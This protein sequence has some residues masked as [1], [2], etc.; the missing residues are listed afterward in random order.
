M[1]LIPTQPPGLGVGHFE[2]SPHVDF[3]HK[4]P[5]AGNPAGWPRCPACCLPPQAHYT[6]YPQHPSPS[7][8]LWGLISEAEVYSSNH[9]E[10]RIPGL[11]PPYLTGTVGSKYRIIHD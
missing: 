4:L 3:P 2:S 1:Y 10:T 6:A 5:T 11:H 8:A 9:T 7:A